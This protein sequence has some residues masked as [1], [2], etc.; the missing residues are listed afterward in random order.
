MQN[1]SKNK[2]K[3][4]KSLHLKKFRDIENAFLVE[5]DKIIQEIINENQELIIDIFQTKESQL[6]HSKT[7]LIS[8]DELKQI[9]TLK[10]PKNSLAI[11]KKLDSK[12]IN[13]KGL[14]LVLD[15]IQDPGNFGTI[16]RLANWYGVKSVI[17]STDTVDCYNPK[18]VQAT[19]GALF[20]VDITYTDILNFIKSNPKP[21]YGTLLSGNNIYKESLDINSY[22]IIG[23]EGNGISLPLKKVIT[24]PITIPKIGLSESL[25]ASVA[26]GIVLS[27]FF[28]NE[29]AK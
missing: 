24:T 2:I 26:T 20:R 12:K 3:Y 21:I 1:I 28:R 18:V 16:I 8:N 9:S 15:N 11:V 25:N 19:M 23:N 17:C 22:L 5:G 13:N 7:I 27:E 10:N 14:T 4:I 6:N 29:L